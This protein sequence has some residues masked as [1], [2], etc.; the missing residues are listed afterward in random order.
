MSFLGTPLTMLGINFLTGIRE[1]WAI[2]FIVPCG[3]GL[4]TLI[5][6]TY[7]KNSCDYEEAF[8]NWRLKKEGKLTGIGSASDLIK[9]WLAVHPGDTAGAADYITETLEIDHSKARQLVRQQ[10]NS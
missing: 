9:E 1:F 6:K 7:F 10:L 5:M 8:D 3:V 4:V 2:W